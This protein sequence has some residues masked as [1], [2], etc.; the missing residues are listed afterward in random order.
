M[1]GTP[2]T[3]SSAERNYSVKVRNATTVAILRL[4]NKRGIFQN[5][6]KTPISLIQKEFFD[7]RSFLVRE[8]GVFLE[9]NR[10]FLTES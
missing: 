3:V 2:N 5:W 8:D 10:L 9:K 6:E 4:S 1:T 7:F